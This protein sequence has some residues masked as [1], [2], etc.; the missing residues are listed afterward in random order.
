M[1]RFLLLAIFSLLLLTN[2]ASAWAADRPDIVLIMADDMGYSDIGCYGGEI[3][4]PVLDRLAEGGVRFTQFYNGARCCPTRASLLTG[5]YAHQAGMGCMEPD[6][7]LPGYR[8]RLN[9][10]CVTLA[11]ALRPAGYST[12]MAGKWHVTNLKRYEEASYQTWPTGRGFDRFYGTIAGAGSFFTPNTLTEGTTEIKPPQDGSFYYTDEISQRTVQFI[13]EHDR[14]TPDRPLFAYVAYTA[15]HWPLHALKED[16]EKYDGR[17]DAGWDKL[18]EERYARMVELGVI[19]RS[20]KMPPASPGHLP[21]ETIDQAELP[22]WV[23]KGAEKH[24]QFSDLQSK[25]KRIMAD[26]M[27]VYAAMV[28]R[29]DQGIGRI[30]AALEKTGRL[31]NAL[32]L[33]LADNGGCAEYGSFGFGWHRGGELGTDSSWA[34]YGAPWAQASNTPFRYYKHYIH[35]GGI[36][37]PLIVHWPAK[38]GDGGKFCRQIGHIIDIMPTMLEAAG[39]VYPTEH[40]GEQIPPMEGRSLMP[41]LEGKSRADVPI[42]WEHH[43]NRGVRLG[44]WK[45]VAAGELS[46]WELYDMQADRTETVNLADAQ[47][48]RVKELESLWTAWAERALVLPMNPNKK[49]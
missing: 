10:K 21:W 17:Y 41:L 11:E 48:K 4:T 28:D 18:R 46:T 7:G 26:K 6:W 43:G 13:E 42:F 24:E 29:M 37:T 19:D 25:I 20:L 44:R 32:I 30:V 39:G 33:F 36:A 12:Y 34:S 38:I 3:A 31:D 35:E 27:E 47:P 2:S 5:L 14:T 15:P 22:D 49:K 8:G 40:A 1:R 9:R 23:S 16:I 45:F